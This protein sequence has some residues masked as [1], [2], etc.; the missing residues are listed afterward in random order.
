MTLDRARPKSQIIVFYKVSIDSTREINCTILRKFEK[1]TV[2]WKI[3]L[4]EMA[5]FRKKAVVSNVWRLKWPWK[6]RNT[7][8]NGMHF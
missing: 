6:H 4:V 7:D 3:Y 5:T 8:K 2:L 1:R